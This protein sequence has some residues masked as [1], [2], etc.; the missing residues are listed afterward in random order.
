MNL[1]SEGIETRSTLETG[2]TEP[3][4]LRF[5]CHYLIDKIP[6]YHVSELF[7][8]LSIISDIIESTITETDPVST[9]DSEP[10]SANIKKLSNKY[11]RTHKKHTPDELEMLSNPNVI[12][13]LNEF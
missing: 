12:R 8:A 6:D 2:R 7:E 13:S 4:T 10:W 5:V 9:G 3:E 11:E 1:E